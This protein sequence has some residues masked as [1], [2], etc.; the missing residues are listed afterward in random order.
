[1]NLNIKDISISCGK[2]Y[3]CDKIMFGAYIKDDDNSTTLVVPIELFKLLNQA[4]ITNPIE[5]L[6]FISTSKTFFAYE[7]KWSSQEVELAAFK[8]YSYL[9]QYFEFDFDPLLPA[10][11]FFFGAKQD[12]EFN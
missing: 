2:N 8:L 10:K 6:L 11:Q 3:K 4:G 5:A 9:L 12:K 7:L 1:V